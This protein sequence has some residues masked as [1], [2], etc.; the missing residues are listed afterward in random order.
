MPALKSGLKSMMLMNK[1]VDT[2]EHGEPQ[3]S[4]VVK[5]RFTRKQ[6]ESFRDACKI[7]E[8]VSL[9]PGFPDFVKSALGADVKIPT[10]SKQF[11]QPILD[12]PIRMPLKLPRST[13]VPAGGPKKESYFTIPTEATDKCIELYNR[14]KGDVV[15]RHDISKGLTCITDVR[16]MISKYI[17]SEDLKSE[18]GIVLDDFIYG[19]APVSLNENSEELALINGR[20][21]IPKSNRK[22]MTGIISEITLGK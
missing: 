8:I 19:L 10:I 3:S 6:Y 21:V 18:D 5:L 2:D 11:V 22:V 7:L 17:A 9:D 4:R 15:L 13:K 14:V 20:Y 12:A 16:V 1:N